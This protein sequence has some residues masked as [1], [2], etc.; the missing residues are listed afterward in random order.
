MDLRVLNTNF[1]EI[2]VLD[3]FESLIWAD[4]YSSCGEFEFY[5][6]KMNPT[7]DLKPDYYITS[8]DSEH[9]MI[10][11]DKNNSSD[12]EDGN[13]L[14]KTGRSLEIILDRRV[15]WVQT[16]LTGNLQNGIKKLLDENLISP[17]DVS[18]QIP[19]FIFEA[20][21]DPAI[22]SLSVEAQFTGDSVYTAVKDLCDS[23]NIGFKVTLNDLN[24]F[25]FKLY[26][27]TDR[28][29][30]QIAHPFIEFS[31][32]F[33]NLINSNYIESKKPLKTV[34]LVAGEGEGA[35]R[36]TISVSAPG[37][38]GSGLSRR[39][40]FTDAR[41]ISSTIDGGTLTTEQYNAQLTQRGS[42]DLAKNVIVKSFE[43]QAETTR[44]YLYGRDF[45]MGDI[46][47]VADTF[48]NESKSR[49]TEVVFS[50]SDSGIDIVPT[51]TTV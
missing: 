37:G 12:V 46:V 10:V 19:N 31:P 9:V 51:F 43:S 4:R 45:F 1:E 15:V 24:Q 29:Y 27:G 30:D 23:K 28:S 7:I 25:V 3:T 16:I 22:T 36:K 49:V 50:Q 47:Q 2:G 11:E 40:M 14:K 35:A 42:E 48:G 21:T 17:T 41:D 32:D 6:S 34:T 26:A 8:D 13:H 33:E 18:R 39:E 38:A 44:M 20:T 5:T